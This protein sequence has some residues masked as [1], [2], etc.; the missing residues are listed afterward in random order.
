[1]VTWS[2]Y[3]GAAFDRSGRPPNSL[4]STPLPLPPSSTPAQ[5]R[6]INIPKCGGAAGRR[7]TRHQGTKTCRR[8]TRFHRGGVCRGLLIAG[9]WVD[10]FFCPLEKKAEG[11]ERYII[12][13]RPQ[14][15]LT[16]E[17]SSN[18]LPPLSAVPGP[19]VVRSE[20]VRDYYYQ[21]TW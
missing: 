19:A 11:K 7:K 17:V 2:F 14:N 1:M 8:R 10:D 16:R 20:D 12:D 3:T 15:H 4:S 13:A 18:S 5:P 9:V 21:L 6:S